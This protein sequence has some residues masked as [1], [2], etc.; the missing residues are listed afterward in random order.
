LSLVGRLLDRYGV[1]RVVLVCVPALS[2][3]Y[4]GF[5][6]VAGSYAVYL[7]LMLLGGI[8]GAGTGA[9][10]YTRPLIAAFDRQRGLALGV[11]A[12]GTSVAAILVPPLLT[13]II[14]D[15]GWRVGIYTLSAVTLCVGLP[16]ALWFIGGNR[17]EKHVDAT[18]ITLADLPEASQ[19][20]K[21]A[22]SVT[23]GGAVR[24]A[25][26]WL[27]A[28]A[29][30]AVN[31]PGSGIV[32]QLAPMLTDKGLSE[33]ATGIALAVY[34]AGLM[35]GR[36]FTGY[37]L[38]RMSVSIVAAAMT[39]IPAVGV[40]ILLVPEPGFVV[41]CVAVALIGLQQGSE[42][43]LLAYFVSRSFGFLHY[44]SIFGA[45][46]TAGALSTATGLVLFG[47]IHDTLGSYDVALMIGAA[48]FLIGAVAFYATGRVAPARP[49]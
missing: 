39:T 27:L 48:A 18:D 20:E 42:V 45:I 16:L 38:D 14:A 28:F 9:I 22:P 49:A 4:L 43:D 23:L 21:Q 35:L 1:R 37:A 8:F 3:V 5:A 36:L 31:I 34:A 32:G 44:S 19:A 12:S 26:F 30:I 29:L 2:L 40:L 13:V 24:S 17:R 47:M 6:T 15:H 11:A 41:A 25:R 7:A 46:A 10:A 33:A